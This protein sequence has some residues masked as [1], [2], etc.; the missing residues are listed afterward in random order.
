MI[1]FGKGNSR[2]QEARRSLN[3][4]SCTKAVLR[5]ESEAKWKGNGYGGSESK[6]SGEILTGDEDLGRCPEEELFDYLETIPGLLRKGNEGRKAG[7]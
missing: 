1:L 4:V 2:L 3:P 5:N 7:K 6:P